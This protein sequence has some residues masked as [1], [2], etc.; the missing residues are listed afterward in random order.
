[1]YKSFTTLG[2]AFIEGI[3]DS[4]LAAGAE[5]YTTHS[6][7]FA[8]VF[9]HELGHNLGMVPDTDDCTCNRSVCVLSPYQAQS[10]KFSNC[11]FIS[12]LR[13]V[14][15]GDRDRLLIP[16]DV[17]KRCVF[18]YCGNKVVEFGEQ[19]DCGSKVACERDPCCQS[20]CML[21]SGAFCAF[22]K[23]CANCQYLPAGTVCRERTD[24]CDL[25]EYC[26]GK[27]EW[28]PEDFYVQ[29]GA[30]CS[31]NSFCYRVLS[32]THADQCQVIFGHSAKD[33]S[34][35]CF[36]R[37]NAQGDRFGT[38]GITNGSYQECKAED[39]LCG[40][41][42][43]ENVKQLSSLME[44]STIIQTPVGQRKCWGTDYHPGTGTAEIGAMRG[45]TKT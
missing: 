21:R 37:V 19:C 44:H 23:Y 42:Q 1:M 32:C 40:R 7:T 39:S 6:H 24:H 30:P 35:D 43:C 10:S 38:C 14:M 22:G 9:A 12:Y 11:S 16:P 41:L 27:S 5:S 15:E 3:C 45:G 26:T 36:R 4:E 20:D 29:D 8:F 18:K 2:V 33:A 28:C 31:S 25:P 34:E 17:E 13:L